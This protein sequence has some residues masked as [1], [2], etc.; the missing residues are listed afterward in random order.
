MYRA[1]VRPI[2]SGVEAWIRAV[3]QQVLK[4]GEVRRISLMTHLCAAVQGRP[5]APQVDLIHLCA[6]LLHQEPHT[7]QLQ[8]LHSSIPSPKFNLCMG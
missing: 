2:R 8:R 3:L 4:D 5:A 1:G 7:G 6:A